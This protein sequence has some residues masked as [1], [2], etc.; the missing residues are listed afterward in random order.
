MTKTWGTLKILRTFSKVK[1]RV[2]KLS[3]TTKDTEVITR[4][5]NNIAP[6]KP[7]RVTVKSTPNIF[8][9]P[10]TWPGEKTLKIAG[11]A[12]KRENKGMNIQVL[13]RKKPSLIDEIVDKNRQ[14]AYREAK[15]RISF[16]RTVRIMNKRKVNPLIL[17]SRDCK[18]PLFKADS[19]AKTD[20]FKKDRAPISERSMK[21]LF[22]N[23]TL[24]AF[25]GKLDYRFNCLL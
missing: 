5:T 6:S 14:N 16:V 22:R 18:K 8:Q 3:S 24:S 19:S 10:K 25:I 21:L 23:I 9:L 11:T 20:S 7:W 17:G 1:C 4:A 15:T 13:L 2:V 12:I